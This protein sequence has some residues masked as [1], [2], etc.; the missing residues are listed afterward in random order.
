MTLN[1]GKESVRSPFGIRSGSVRDPFGVPSG[2]V[3]G[4]FEVVR[5]RFSV[6]SGSVHR[7]RSGSVRGPFGVCAGCFKASSIS[8]AL[9]TPWRKWILAKM[10]PLQAK[11][12]GTFRLSSRS[13]T[14]A[15]KNATPGEL[16]GGAP[17]PSQRPIQI[18]FSVFWLCNWRAK[19]RP[20]IN[21]LEVI[22]TTS[23]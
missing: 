12:Q 21:A 19:Q 20:A 6:R 13:A 11:R 23:S 4:P 16:R 18:Q 7:I 8:P 14:A 17:R 10:T 2:S 22:T 15:K 9:E 1:F 3:R 5:D